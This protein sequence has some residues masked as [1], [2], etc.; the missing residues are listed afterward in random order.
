VNAAFRQAW[1]APTRLIFVT[2]DRPLPEGEEAIVRAWNASL[3]SAP[4]AAAR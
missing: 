4:G 1:S 2:H 3:S